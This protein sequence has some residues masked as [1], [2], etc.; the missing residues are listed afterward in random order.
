MNGYGPDEVT[1]NMV[2]QMY[3][4]A[5]HGPGTTAKM[6]FR[7]D[8]EYRNGDWP[9]VVDIPSQDE[10]KDFDGWLDFQMHPVSYELL[11]AILYTI[12]GIDT[13]Q[14]EDQQTAED[15]YYSHFENDRF[16]PYE[17]PSWFV[18]ASVRQGSGPFVTSWQTPAEYASQ[19]EKGNRPWTRI[20]ME[21][22]RLS[23]KEPA[24][25]RPQGTKTADNKK[26][27]RIKTPAPAEWQVP[28]VTSHDSSANK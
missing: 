11:G 8:W 21:A 5:H 7:P 25:K 22:K 6:Q 24:R 10:G 4:L 23:E 9:E 2:L 14:C 26:K 15:L 18:N 1:N 13:N 19:E 28:Y 20:L 27:L 16:A 17:L 3:A 12:L